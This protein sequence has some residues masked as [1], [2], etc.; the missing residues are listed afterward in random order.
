MAVDFKVVFHI[1]RVDPLIVIK[2]QDISV[3]ANSVF[4]GIFRIDYPNGSFQQNQD[5]QS[6]DISAIGGEVEYPLIIDPNTNDP[7]I[8]EYKVTY[9]VLNGENL[10]VKQKQFTL[11]WSE[12]EMTIADLSDV[13]VPQVRFQDHTDYSVTN[14]TRTDLG[15]TLSCQLP[16]TSDASGESSTSVGTTLF[17]ADASLNTYEGEYSPLLLSEMDYDSTV[18]T[19]LS[20]YWKKEEDD[21]FLIYKI[22]TILEIL[23]YI[24]NF[25]ESMDEYKGK[26]SIEYNEL[27][28]EFQ[29]ILTLYTYFTERSLF[30]FDLSPNSDTKELLSRLNI[31]RDNYSFQP[32]PIDG[33]VLE[34]TT[35]IEGPGTQGRIPVYKS[36]TAIKDSYLYQLLNQVVSEASLIFTSGSIVIPPIGTP[37][38]PSLD[39][40]LRNNNGELEIFGGGGWN[41][42]TPREELASFTVRGTSFGKYEDGDTVPAHANL[43]ERFIDMG[44]KA[45]LPTFDLPIIGIAGDPT[46]TV[47]EVGTSITTTLMITGSLNDAGTATNFRIQKDGINVLNG[48]TTVSKEE[49]FVLSLTPI[50]FKAIVDYAA[51]TV[52]KNDNL[53]NSIPNPITAGTAESGNLSYVG[54]RAVFYGSVAT[55]QINSAGVRT[56]TKI[57]ESTKSFTLNTGTNNSIFQIWL[58]SG[59][60]IISVIDLDALNANITSNYISE[61]LNV[62]DAGGNPISG[63]LYTMT[64][65]VAY[66]SNHRHQIVIS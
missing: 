8:G 5:M 58:P 17:V 62:N 6:P 32:G 50:V 46:N 43:N 1:D 23:Q 66:T 24:E 61:V 56:L 33:F 63:N 48:F 20:V 38:I 26:N 31:N 14:Y 2:L 54:R 29:G 13:A 37:L 57:L 27:D 39:G 18:Y 28:Q 60:N 47:L 40:A 36:E 19:Y 12:P 42:V 7:L 52:P 22:P 30:N 21:T 53:G 10:E 65:D 51:G 49:T 44:T 25:K 59:I 11:D 45:I 55:K 4:R 3:S 35:G 15:R 9:T 41:P 34:Y 64:A 16:S